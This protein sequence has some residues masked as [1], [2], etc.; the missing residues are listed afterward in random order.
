MT[1]DPFAC[2]RV[3]VPGQPTCCCFLLLSQVH[4]R[5][6]GLSSYLLRVR[7]S[8]PVGSFRFKDADHVQ[9]YATLLFVRAL[10]YR[11]VMGSMPTSLSQP[12]RRAFP[13][14]F[15]SPN[16]QASL[17]V[18]LTTRLNLISSANRSSP[19]NPTSTHLA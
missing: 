15:K 11:P 19:S 18:L 12:L 6:K 4:R 5:P 9:Y 3:Q 13:S 7:F 14:A 16:P 8:S 17:P 1:E 10:P 2:I